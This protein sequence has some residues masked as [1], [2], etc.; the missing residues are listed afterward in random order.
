MRVKIKKLH[1]EAHLPEYAH[2]PTEDAGL[3][4]R[5]VSHGR[6]HDSFRAIEER[7]S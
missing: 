2:G 7:F 5:L 6:V 1:S 4:I 3:D